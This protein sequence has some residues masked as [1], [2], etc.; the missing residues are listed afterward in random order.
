MSA[1]ARVTAMWRFD[2]RRRQRLWMARLPDL[3]P[4]RR[5]VMTVFGAAWAA[6]LIGLT[7]VLTAVYG[8]AAIGS[9]SHTAD[10]LIASGILVLAALRL[11]NG[12][13]PSG[14]SGVFETSDVQLMTRGP[15]SSATVVLARFWL[16]QTV[17]WAGV[18]LTL[19]IAWTLARAL[20]GHPPVTIPMTVVL[21]LLL[22]SVQTSLALSVLMTAAVFRA[23][24]VLAAPLLTFSEMLSPAAL[25]LLLGLLLPT[26]VDSL[27]SLHDPWLQT[28]SIIDALGTDAAWTV[29]DSLLG[30]MSSVVA[31]VICCAVSTKLPA[32]L[33]A[34]CPGDYQRMLQGGLRWR[35]GPALPED[36]RL[37]IAAKDL[38]M[39]V[40]R[41]IPAWRLL[42][43]VVDLVPSLIVLVAAGLVVSSAEAVIGPYLL[44][45]ANVG[46]V[47]VIV[48]MASEAFL[49]LMSADADGAALRMLS[50]EGQARRRFVYI[51]AANAAVGL[52]LIG[53]IAVGAIQVLSPWPGLSAPLTLLLVGVSAA[54]EA[55]IVVAGTVSTPALVRPAVGVAEPEP[56]VRLASAVSTGV[57]MALGIPVVLAG[58]HLAEGHWTLLAAGVLCTPFVSRICTRLV[59]S[60]ALW[61]RPRPQQSTKFM[62]GI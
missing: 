32:A 4:H 34:R 27:S 24:A 62:K 40:R 56:G 37:L 36:V 12:L 46:L 9:G 7:L 8:L 23:P 25:V 14:V 45:S 60:T 33:N 3:L 28:M 26:V 38:R 13:T 18:A 55:S 59:V 51:K 43:D 52:S 10:L 2:R 39:L 58:S 53:V 16:P 61:D 30:L 22:V 47:L 44:L 42:Q 35:V 29:A 1:A 41:G 5:R 21:I 31:L 19:G 6:V 49:P 48:A 57:G 54:V 11:V 20:T 50:W 15:V 17:L